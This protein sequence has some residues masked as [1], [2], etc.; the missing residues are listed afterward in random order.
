MREHRESKSNRTRLLS[1]AT[2][3]WWWYR[4]LWTWCGGTAAAKLSWP[5]MGR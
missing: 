2:K 4:T 5:A 3:L 1:A